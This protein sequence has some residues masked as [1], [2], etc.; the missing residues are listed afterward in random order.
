MVPTNDPDLAEANL[1]N[2]TIQ[3]TLGPAESSC[4]EERF[5]IVNQDT[6]KRNYYKSR[7]VTSKCLDSK[8]R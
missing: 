7:Y 6:Y 8:L 2:S 3:L 5:E 4:H 1:D